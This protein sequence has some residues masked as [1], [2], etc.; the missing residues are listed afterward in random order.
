M[1]HGLDSAANQY[2]AALDPGTDQAIATGCA[3]LAQRQCLAEQGGEGAGCDA[4]GAVFELRVEV[5]EVASFKVVVGVIGAGT[6]PGVQTVDAG[7][8]A[9]L[10]DRLQVGRQCVQGGRVAH[11]DQQF[12]AADR[13]DLRRRGDGCCGD[14][15]QMGR[16]RWCDGRLRHDLR[17]QAHEQV[18]AFA[19][20]CEGLAVQGGLDCQRRMGAGAREQAIGG[21]QGGV[22][23]QWAAHVRVVEVDNGRDAVFLRWI[24]PDAGGVVFPREGLAC[25]G[26]RWI[27]FDHQGR[28]AGACGGAEAAEGMDFHCFSF[29]SGS[30]MDHSG[31]RLS[32]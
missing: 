2:G 27:V 28:I 21:G 18:V 5:V 6:A 23:A 26:V 14:A 30:M 20:Q 16:Q 3:A 15:E 19:R 31:S 24:D 22:Q 7:L 29:V 1:S 11:L 17:R 32:G 4:G 9:P 13:G 10:R 8:L 25:V 12:R